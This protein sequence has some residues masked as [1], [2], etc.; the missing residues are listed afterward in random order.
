MFILQ[1]AQYIVLSKDYYLHMCEMSGSG[2]SMKVIIQFL[3]RLVQCNAFQYLLLMSLSL[4]CINKKSAN[5]FGVI[6]GRARQLSF[7]VGLFLCFFSRQE[8]KMLERELDY[9]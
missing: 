5:T 6:S 3:T 2:K 8:I 9:Y 7:S 1:G 4:T